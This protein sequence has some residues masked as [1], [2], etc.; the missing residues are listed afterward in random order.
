MMGYYIHNVPGRL[1]VK[2][3][4]IKNNATAVDELKMAL[5]TI[6]GIATTDINLIT[7][8]LLVNYNPKAVK[9]NDIVAVLE[10]RGYFDASRAMTQD[11]YLQKAALEAGQIV[12]RAVLG[13]FVENALK[14]S[15]LAILTLLI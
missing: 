9:Q 4:A 12:G 7:G 8:S 15:P 14:G 5:S 13:S 1:R 2:S 6:E 11:E 3:P 10:R